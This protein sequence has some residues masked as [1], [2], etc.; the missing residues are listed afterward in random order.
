MAAEMEKSGEIQKTYDMWF[1]QPSPAEE[2]QGGPACQR[3]PPEAAWANPNDKPLEEYPEEVFQG[4]GQTSETPPG[5]CSGGVL[6]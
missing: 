3:P 6:L 4:P 2:H 5:Y 1:V